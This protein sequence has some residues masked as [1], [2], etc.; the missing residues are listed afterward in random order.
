MDLTPY[1]NTIS[2]LKDESTYGNLLSMMIM[3]KIGMSKD[4]GASTLLNLSQKTIMGSLFWA[5]DRMVSIQPRFGIHPY[6]SHTET[7]L[8][9]YKLLKNIGGYEKELELIRNYFFEIR[10]TGFWLNTFEASRI[11]ETIIP[12]MLE[13][14]ES[15]SNI[16]IN[17]NGEKITTLPYS[18]ETQDNHITV[19]KTGTTPLFFSIYQSNWDPNPKAK[20]EGFSIETIFHDSNDSTALLVAGKPEEMKVIVTVEGDAEYVMIEVPIPAG[21]TYEQKEME[22][23]W[24]EAHREYFKDKVSIFCNRLKKGKHIFTIKLLPRYSGEYTLNPAKVELMYFPTFYGNEII[25]EVL[26]KSE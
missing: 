21:C 10:K 4:I 15:F 23:R 18:G 26:I 12:D 22:Y 19:Q 1:F 16:K 24:K 2:Q 25:K 6:I 17:I 8:M 9:A 7:T 5:D 3:S 14:G 13:K 11:I 20:S